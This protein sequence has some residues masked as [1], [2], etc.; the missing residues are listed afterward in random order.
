[1]SINGCVTTQR[2]REAGLELLYLHNIS[3]QREQ[4]AEC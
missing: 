4:V 3:V 2:E 1:M